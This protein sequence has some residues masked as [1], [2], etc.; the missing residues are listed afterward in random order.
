MYPWEAAFTGADV[1]PGESYIKSEVHVTADVAFALRQ[2]LYATNDTTI[3]TDRDTNGAY[4]IQV[5]GAV[6]ESF[7]NTTVHFVPFSH[8]LAVFALTVKIMISN[9]F[10]IASAD[11]AVAQYHQLLSLSL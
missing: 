6:N 7:H 3:L 5:I 4:V 2:Y 1:C 10:C 9:K 11:T 8:Q